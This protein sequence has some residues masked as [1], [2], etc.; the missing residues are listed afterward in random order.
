MTNE[1]L[2]SLKKLP[3]VYARL[4]EGLRKY[5]DAIAEGIDKTEEFKDQIQD[6]VLGLDFTSITDM[7]VNSVTDPSIDNALEELEVN[8]DK[9]IA[10]I[11]MNMLRRNMLLGPL[12]KMTMTYISRW[13]RRIRMAILITN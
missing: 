10:S 7:I 6:T 4:P 3:E 13:R 11:A 8:I 12:E 1:Q 5:I 2:A 9:T